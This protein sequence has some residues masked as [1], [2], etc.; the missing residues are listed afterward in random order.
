[1]NV[2]SMEKKIAVVGALA[3][4]ASIRSINRM[5]GIHQTTIMNLGMKIGEG[6]FLLMDAF[7][8]GLIVGVMVGIATEN[9]AWGIAAG[10]F[11]LSVDRP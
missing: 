5:T 9:F 10:F 7:M 8:R 4:G 2:L 1:M 11:T 3:E 6:C